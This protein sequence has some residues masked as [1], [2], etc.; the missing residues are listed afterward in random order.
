MK[1]R[2]CEQL[3][4]SFVSFSSSLGPQQQEHVT[5]IRTPHE[6]SR[7]LLV[8]SWASAAGRRDQHPDTCAVVSRPGPC[9]GILWLRLSGHGDHVIYTV[10]TMKLAHFFEGQNIFIT[11]ASGF[12]GKV[13]VEKLLRSC[14]EIQTIYLLFRCKEGQNAQERDVASV[15][16]GVDEI[17]RAE[18]VRNV[19]V[20]FHLAASVRFDEPLK[21]AVIILGN[22]PNT[23]VFT[24]ALSESIIYEARNE[25]PVVIFRPSIGK[26]KKIINHTEVIAYREKDQWGCWLEQG[27]VW[28]ELRMRTVT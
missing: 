15:G 6:I 14:R 10:L 12:M 1:Y 19:T 25:L 26:K 3:T 13:L 9:P 5:N 22:L 20:I 16:L 21:S 23:Y 28:Y 27:Q 24:K 8:L 17:S 7:Q 11:G 18:L 4:K 2:V